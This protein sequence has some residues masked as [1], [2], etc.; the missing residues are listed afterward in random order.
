ML[1]QR[2][3]EDLY[4]PPDRGMPEMQWLEQFFPDPKKKCLKENILNVKTNKG[5]K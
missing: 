2:S 4:Y 3:N 5:P 1:E